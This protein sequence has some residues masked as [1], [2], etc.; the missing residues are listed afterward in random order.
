MKT[1]T[2]WR[3]LIRLA[4]EEAKAR[5]TGDKAKI[6]KAA[7]AHEDYRK[8]CLESDGMLLDGVRHDD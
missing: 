4:K 1:Y 3:V 7:K 6:K 5:K 8:L 2:V